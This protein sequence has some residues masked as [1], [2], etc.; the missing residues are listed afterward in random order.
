MKAAIYGLHGL[1]PSAPNSDVPL[2][3]NIYANRDMCNIVR[4]V[5]GRDSVLEK[6][7]WNALPYG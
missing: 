6:V 2:N 1:Q 7:L 4:T 5:I 3:F